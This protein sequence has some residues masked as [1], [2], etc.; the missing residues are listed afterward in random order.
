MMNLTAELIAL[1][2][3]M[4]ATYEANSAADEYWFGFILNH[5]VYVVKN[6]GFDGLAKYFKKDVASSRRGGF[7]KIRIRAKVDE[8]AELL[9]MAEALCSEEELRA[10]NKNIGRAFEKLIYKRF[11]TE[12]WVADS[13]PFFEAGDVRIDGKE[14]QLKFNDSELTNEKILKRYFA[15]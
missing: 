11:T 4:I 7:T 15:A 3:W 5:V 2:N 1:I 13:V 10:M 12:E 14:I 9:P 8:L 6:I